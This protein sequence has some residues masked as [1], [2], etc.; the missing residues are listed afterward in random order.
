M[1]HTACLVSLVSSAGGRCKNALGK[2]IAIIW[3]ATNL[4]NL[5]FFRYLCKRYKLIILECK[6]KHDITQ[7][8][9]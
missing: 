2:G 8:A 4:S 6:Q 7:E 9:G 3:Q 5:L 1:T